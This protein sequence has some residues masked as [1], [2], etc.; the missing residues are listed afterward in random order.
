[1]KIVLSNCLSLTLKVF[2]K[3]LAEKFW[4]KFKNDFWFFSINWQIKKKS[5]EHYIFQGHSHINKN[6]GNSSPSCKICGAFGHK[7]RKVIFKYFIKI[8]DQTYPAELIF[9][10]QISWKIGSA[11][12]LHFCCW[13]KVA[14]IKKKLFIK[15]W[16]N[17]FNCIIMKNETFKL[18]W[19]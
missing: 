9:W 3:P 18:L 2:L 15:T 7:V 1:M 4:G 13:W 8:L 5:T 10:V 16:E 6:L 14:R 19:N 11:Q 17:V 12:G